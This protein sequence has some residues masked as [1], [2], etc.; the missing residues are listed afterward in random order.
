MQSG[1]MQ[2]VT[3]QTGVT[4][5]AKGVS[6]QPGP[7]QYACQRLNHVIAVTRMSHN[8]QARTPLPFRSPTKPTEAVYATSVKGALAPVPVVGQTV[9]YSGHL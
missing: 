5:K 3:G 6:S 8:A 1:G 4:G 9:D 7:G 2:P